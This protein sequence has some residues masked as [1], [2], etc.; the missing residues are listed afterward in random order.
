MRSSFYASRARLH[1]VHSSLT[2]VV[3]AF[4]RC[5]VLEKAYGAQ[6]NAATSDAVR[7]H[8]WTGYN[9]A[10]WIPTDPAV[11]FVDHELIITG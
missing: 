8:L 9:L 5:F 1:L 3:L 7:H 4:E 2:V 11:I 6:G 10:P